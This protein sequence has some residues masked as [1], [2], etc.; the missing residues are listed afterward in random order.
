FLPG[1]YATL[2]GINSAGRIVFLRRDRRE[3]PAGARLVVA[4]DGLSGRLLA[5]EPG[6]R[7]IIVPNSPIGAGAIAP[8]APTFYQAGTIYMACGAAGY[9]GLVR[10][11]D[12]RLDIAA[13][14]DR[15]AAQRAGGPAQ[16]AAHLLHDVGW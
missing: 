12:G 15:S 1:T 10:L 16:L 6:I 4:A 2:A 7:T 8:E 11:E 14:L 9:V 5:G 3:W 13:A